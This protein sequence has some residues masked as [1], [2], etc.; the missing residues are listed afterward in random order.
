[1]RRAFRFILITL[2]ALTAAWSGRPGRAVLGARA[3]ITSERVPL[4]PGN[5][6]NL[7]VGALTYLGG[8][9]LSSSD[10]A[11]GG[12]SSM[13]VKGDRFTLLSDG[14]NIVRFTMDAQFRITAPDFADLPAGP[15]LGWTKSDRDSESMAVD[16]ASGNVWVG[17]ERA[18]EIWRYSPGLTAPVAHVAPPEMAGWAENGG[19]ESLVRLR[20]GRFLVIAETDRR[21]HSG[22][23]RN[24]LLFARDPVAGKSNGFGFG[25]VPPE[26]YDP[27]DAVELPDGRVLVLNRRIALPFAWSA[28]LTLLDP[29]TFRA[30]AILRGREVATLAPPL[31]VDNFEG[32]AVTKEGNAT[33]LWMV[34]DDNLFVLQRSLLMKFRLSL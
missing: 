14:G 22:G 2:L 23:A 31:N 33:I 25:Y 9:T 26:G 24:A 18:N 20:D 5:P 6:A 16:P 4:D 13:S 32:L 3:D 17:F 11:F 21:R 15:G 29:R 19:A 34:S 10:G 8:V 28:K 7:T 30:N 12:F 27:S 1:M